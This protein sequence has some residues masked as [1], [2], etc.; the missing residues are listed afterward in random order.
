MIFV[1]KITRE[2]SNSIIKQIFFSR[3]FYTFIHT[4]VC[5]NYLFNLV[6]VMDPLEYQKNISFFFLREVDDERNEKKGI[7]D[8]KLFAHI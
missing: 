3:I 8:G 4:Y 6:Y 1:H 5:I 7:F 2:H